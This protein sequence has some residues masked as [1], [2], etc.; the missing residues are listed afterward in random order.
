MEGKPKVVT[1][2]TRSVEEVLEVQETPDGN[3][4][5]IRRFRSGELSLAEHSLAGAV[6]QDGE[7]VLIVQQPQPLKSIEMLLTVVR[8]QQQKQN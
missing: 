1:T 2:N 8:E 3:F 6:K 7:W 5:L 4:A